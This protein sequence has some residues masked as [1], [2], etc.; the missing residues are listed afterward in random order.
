MLWLW[1]HGWKIFIGI[2]QLVDLGKRITYLANKTEFQNILHSVHWA[3]RLET[4][5]LVHQS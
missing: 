4:S 2:S 5:L 3:T 1:V